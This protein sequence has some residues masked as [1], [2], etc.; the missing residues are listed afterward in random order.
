VTIN[1][2]SAVIM[3]SMFFF[4]IYIKYRQNWLIFPGIILLANYTSQIRHLTKFGK[5]SVQKCELQW[6]N[7]KYKQNT[8]EI[9][10]IKKN[11]FSVSIS[12]VFNLDFPGFIF[13]FFVQCPI[14]M[15]WRQ[16]M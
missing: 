15:F 10:T 11:R 12:L 8:G 13:Y 9:Q 14:A 6:A 3:P 5:E 16:L 1:M 7:L 2:S 4:S